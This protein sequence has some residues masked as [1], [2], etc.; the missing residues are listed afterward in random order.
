VLDREGTNKVY[1]EIDI[2]LF[3]TLLEE[4]LGLTPIE[5]MAFGVPVVASKIGA[6]T[7]Y[8][9]HGKN[10]FLIEPGSADD[11]TKT[12]MRV[13]NLTEAEYASLSFEARSV[14]AKYDEK[15]IV[16]EYRSVFQRECNVG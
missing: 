16:E 15:K 5:A 14:A 8:I 12:L 3:P 6:V 2:L 11:L 4:S 10:G 13:N 1:E 7:E 9:E